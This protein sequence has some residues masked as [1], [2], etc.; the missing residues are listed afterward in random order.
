MCVRR[1]RSWIF[2]YLRWM[3][4]FLDC[5]NVSIYWRRYLVC[6]GLIYLTFLGHFW[7]IGS[8]RFALTAYGILFHLFQAIV[9]KARQVAHPVGRFHRMPP[10]RTSEVY[11]D[12][13][14]YR[15]IVI[16]HLGALTQV[17]I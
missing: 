7:H 10:N 3:I 4:P 15:L 12:L 9:S 5:T 14:R 8:M 6:I 1:P 11:G 17:K 13:S 2:V 16:A